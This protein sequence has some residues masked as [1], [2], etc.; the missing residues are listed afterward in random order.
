MKKRFILPLVALLFVPVHLL[1]AN[2]QEYVVLGS[3]DLTSANSYAPV[4]APAPGEDIIFLNGVNYSPTA[5][6]INAASIAIGTLDDT[7]GNEALTISNTTSTTSTL[8]LDGGVNGAAG[9]SPG[10][11]LYVASGGGLTINSGTA[12]PLNMVLG[13]S[14]SFDVAGA[15]T[16]NSN[17]SG[18]YD[19]VE[20]GGGALTLGG[21]N[22]FNSMTVS[23]GTL[24][25]TNDNAAGTGTITLGNASGP[26]TNVALGIAYN[27]SSGPGIGT[28]P[29]PVNIV[30]TGTNTIENLGFYPTLGG[31]VTLN[32]GNSVNIV[33]PNYNGSLTLSGGVTGTGNIIFLGNTNGGNGIT[34]SGSI[35]AVGT[36]SNLGTST[37]G[38]II[39]GNI[40]SNISG[41]TENSPSGSALTLSGSNTFTGPLTIDAGAV[42]IGNTYAL[43]AATGIILGVSGSTA[44]AT[45]NTTGGTPVYTGPVNVFG[46][47]TNTIS[48]TGFNPTY[49]GTVT[50]NSANLNLVPNNT[51]GSTITV[52]ALITGTGNLVIQDN[53]PTGTAG[54]DTLVSG[55]VNMVGSI[56]NSGTGGDANANTTIS[57][58][59]G[60]NVTGIVENSA[61]S[62]LTLSGSNS[63]TGG[64]TI[65]NGIVNVSGDA[66][67]ASSSIDIGTITLGDTA[68]T[69]AS[70]TLDWNNNTSFNQSSPINVVGTGNRVIEVTSW[71]PTISGA[72]TLNSGITLNFIDSN[73][74]GS[75]M[76]VTGGITGSGNIVLQQNTVG[77]THGIAI[78]LST[79]AINNA[80]TITN[81]GTG[82][83]GGTG[84]TNNTISA[85]IGSNV[86]GIYESGTYSA[87]ILSGSNTY[88]GDTTV[89]TGT[90]EDNG[91]YALQNSVLNLNATSGTATFA[92]ASI[93]GGLAGSG[94]LGSNQN[95]SIGN[96]NVSNGSITNPNT[97]NPT[98]SGNLNGSMGLTKIGANTQTL[99]G[100]LSYTGA[101][102]VSLGT[103]VMTGTSSTGSLTIG[104]N[105]TD[106]GTLLIS[107][108]SAFTSVTVG[109]NG[110]GTL[111]V[112]TTGTLS[113]SA[114][115]VLA[116][117]ATSTGT[118]N[119]NGVFN[120]NDTSISGITLAQTAGDYGVMNVSGTLNDT[121]GISITYKGTGVLNLNAGGSITVASNPG[122]TIA[123]NQSTAVGTA[124]LSG[125]LTT[126]SGDLVVSNG[127]TGVLNMLSGTTS[128]ANGHY[129]YVNEANSTNGSSGTVNMSGGTL[130]ANGIIFGNSSASSG[131]NNAIFNLTG[132]TVDFTSNGGFHTGSYSVTSGPT[133][134]NTQLNLGGG[135]LLGST[136]WNLPMNAT[137]TGNGGNVTFQASNLAGTSPENISVTGTL[138]GSGGLAKTGAGSLT[139]G[140]TNSYTGSTVIVAG[141]LSA[142]VA[143]AITSSTNIDVQSAGT[144]DISGANVGAYNLSGTQTVMGNGTINAGKTL[145]NVYGTIQPHDGVTNIG[146]LTVN[147]SGSGSALTLENNS[148]FVLNLGAT[149]SDALVANGVV[150][151]GANSGDTINLTI[152]LTAQ[153]VDGTL[154]AILTGGSGDLTN[155]GLFSYNGTPLVG[156]TPFLV[157]NNGYGEYF[158]VDYGST[159]DELYAYAVP[160]P[161]TWASLAIG[162]GMLLGAQRLRRR[163][164]A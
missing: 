110:L 18:S 138:S 58:P 28:V 42:N 5:F 88:Y 107:G 149:T 3:T 10:D 45:I 146:T 164:R 137:L 1:H 80:G 24:E 90:L 73:T 72:I 152:N 142:T 145:V 11:L 9:A 157:S 7:V 48:V 44:N 103:L 38:V 86:T 92:Q 2:T 46:S 131:T 71:N 148:N 116:Y 126:T 76:T 78:T 53:T 59:I 130:E 104:N 144:L 154:Y 19:V 109:N 51:G 113:A 17:I 140:A 101:T 77:N 82:T 31:L 98:Y 151:L 159:S 108:S 134:S 119:I 84:A 162:L 129:L 150:N 112:A 52:S 93:L 30:G 141:S 121:G 22:S 136:G 123:T 4:A 105:T 15:A 49:S 20:S 37:V 57:G 41:I 100:N 74:G 56:T 70:A 132:G 133:A 160:E 29:N 83:V 61:T 97:L 143:A 158:E 66:I 156:N 147:N 16:I 94:T 13:A 111:N 69:G 127:G 34:E 120:E 12:T 8:T 40:G 35:G 155:N 25:L 135:T 33:D 118:A 68:N 102:I 14:G 115:F 79:G 96:S 85:Q 91:V 27:G 32:G 81:S 114:A 47:G 62:Q 39:S 153:P 128:I 163:S 26:V 161:G 124:N 139:L 122:L 63:F 54:S 95:L 64:L 50:L 67:S 6:T 21:S 106:N 65:K 125:N 36:I 99:S 87:L 60:A 75:S 23:A 55:T 117:A 89:T 43:G